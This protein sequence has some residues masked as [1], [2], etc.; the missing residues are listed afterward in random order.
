MAIHLHKNM[1]RRM[2]FVSVFLGLKKYQKH[3]KIVLYW[4]GWIFVITA[5]TLFTGKLTHKLIYLYRH[6]RPHILSGG[7]RTNLSH[8]WDRTIKTIPRRLTSAG[9]DRKSYSIPSQPC[10]RLKVSVA[11]L[12]CSN[13]GMSGWQESIFYLC[14]NIPDEW[15]PTQ[16]DTN[17]TLCSE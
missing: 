5:I 6:I 8:G 3:A 7:V 11:T 10:W 13:S 17:K 15:E 12:V 4:F 14:S 1:I 2:S 9:S 16:F